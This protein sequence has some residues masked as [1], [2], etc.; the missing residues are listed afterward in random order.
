[1]PGYFYPDSEQETNEHND[2]ER[3]RYENEIK[4]DGLNYKYDDGDNVN[5]GDKVH[6]YDTDGSGPFKI[7][8][9]SLT[10]TVH[11]QN[12]KLCVDG[13][14]LALTCAMHVDKVKT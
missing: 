9:E 5:I 14:D 3:E 6:C 7:I 13:N 1:M 2:Q 4:E 11:M 12:G 8:T 10:G